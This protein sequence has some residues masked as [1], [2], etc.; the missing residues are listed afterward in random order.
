MYAARNILPIN[1]IMLIKCAKS[2]VD[3]SRN[4]VLTN[5]KPNEDLLLRQSGDSKWTTRL[6]SYY[7]THENDTS[8]LPVHFTAIDKLHKRFCGAD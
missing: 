5:Y 3:L 1:I 6:S 2:I 4:Q 7:V 8:V